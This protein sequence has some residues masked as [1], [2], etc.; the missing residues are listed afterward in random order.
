MKRSYE[1][2]TK[3][4]FSGTRLYRTSDLDMFMRKKDEVKHSKN[5]IIVF[6][7][8]NYEL[9]YDEVQFIGYSI[10]RDKDS[11]VLNLKSQPILPIGLLNQFPNKNKPLEIILKPQLFE[12]GELPIIPASKMLITNPTLKY[13]KDATS[14]NIITTALINIDEIPEIRKKRL[15]LIEQIKNSRYEEQYSY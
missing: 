13:F 8:G 2:W 6:L 5:G 9:S 11:L 12:N 14:K 7:E 10:I 15:P 1:C 3:Q 4:F